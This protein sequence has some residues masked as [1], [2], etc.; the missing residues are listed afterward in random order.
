MR[1][2]LPGG[3][4]FRTAFFANFF[5]FCSFSLRVSP[6]ASCTLPLPTHVVGFCGLF[7]RHKRLLLFR[8][9]PPPEMG[10]GLT[11]VGDLISAIRSDGH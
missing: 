4:N 7:P 3:L 5:C 2:I 1:E 9:P 10:G 8:L 11:V 6:R